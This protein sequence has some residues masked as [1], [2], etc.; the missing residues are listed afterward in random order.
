VGLRERVLATSVGN[1][2]Y[3]LAH[4]RRFDASYRAR[5]ERYA[6][7]AA[8]D[9]QAHDPEAALARARAKIAARGHT[10]KARRWGD[11]HTFAF[12]PSNWSHQG[13]I[14]RAAE[15]LGPVTRFDYTTLGIKLSELRN[16]R[17]AAP[18]LRTRVEA[19]LFAA[20]RRAAAE[21]PIDWFFAYALP[22]DLTPTMLRRVQEEL[23]IP[24]V[25]ISLDDKNWWDEIERGDPGSA[26]GPYVTRFDLGWTS[27]RVV[28]PWYWADGGQ[29]IYLP[30]GANT[31]WF[32]PLEGVEPDIDVGF[33]GSRMG[34]RPEILERLRAVGIEVAVHGPGWPSGPLEDEEMR[35]FFNRCR[36]NL[37]L[38]DMFY[39]RW[40]TN[41][42]GRD[43]EVPATGRGVYLTTY[44]CDL[45]DCFH[46]GRELSCYRGIDEMIELIRRH[47][48]RPDEAR[49]MAA[50][51]RE[52]VLR[53]HQWKHRFEAVVRALGVLSGPAEDAG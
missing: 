26:M 46:L 45:A 1:R 27:A 25:N 49:E 43:F 35:R 28:L 32:R 48:A 31:D 42:K 23:G 52:R 14:A 39:S 10:V 18:E 29:A 44:N 13:Q 47:L 11:I 30:E 15:A 17:E 2:V 19:E 3:G 12:V 53:E 7:R 16:C 38:G 36:V 4:E 9:A 8:G 40:L 24:T 6:L 20:L 51:A 5:R 21:R 33:V 22:W 37:G 34:H 41:L 50:R